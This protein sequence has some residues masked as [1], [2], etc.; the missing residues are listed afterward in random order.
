MRAVITGVML[1]LLSGPLTAL[2]LEGRF[3]V[4]SGSEVVTVLGTN[5]FE[6]IQPQLVDFIQVYPNA[7]I[8]YLMASSAEIASAL[9]TDAIRG[10]D[11][12]LSSALDLQMKA[13][14]DGAA[15]TVRISDPSGTQW[16]DRLFQISLEPIVTLYN[17]AT[18]PA[19]GT[20]KD[21]FELLD[22]LRQGRLSLQRGVVLYDPTRSGVGYLLAAQDAEQ[23]DVFWSLLEWFST[24]RLIESCCSVDM[25]QLVSSGKVDLAYNILE[26]YAT[27]EL[28]TNPDLHVLAFS[29][30]QLLVPRTAFVPTTADNPDRGARFIEYLRSPRAQSLLPAHMQLNRL[31]QQSNSPLKPIRMSPALILQLDAYQKARFLRQW[32]SATSR[33]GS[34]Q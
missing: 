13:V 9:G 22:Q 4:G 19:L 11:A 34:A 8:N 6:A 31:Q 10:I 24:P 17:K 16:R 18:N 1:A 27:A 3:E 33:S 32:N 21:R 26:S 29:D 23:I 14:N 2:T 25:I 5:E 30:Y 12:I 15:R 28:A 20:I 7:Q